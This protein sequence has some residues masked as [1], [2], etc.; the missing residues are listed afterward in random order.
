MKWLP[1]SL[2]LVSS[3]LLGTYFARGWAGERINA[4]AAAEARAL[5]EQLA[6]GE[7]ELRQAERG[8]LG[9]AA[10]VDESAEPADFDSD[11]ATPFRSKRRF[12]PAPPAEAV[13][14][15]EGEVLAW[16]RRETVP[17]AVA[18]RVE[19]RLPAGIEILGG[20]SF[21]PALAPGDRLVE[22]DGVPVVNREEAVRQVLAARGRRQPRIAARFVRLT[23]RGLE[24][25]SVVIA[26]PY[27]P[28]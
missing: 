22:V 23:A 4:R 7:R 8:S 18:R 10:A 2:A 5:G 12:G 14:I 25:F 24:R 11:A 15:G 3:A 19:G 28:E 9:G 20:E 21:V 26:Q 27:D 6:Q 13:V 1:W 17:R 16:A